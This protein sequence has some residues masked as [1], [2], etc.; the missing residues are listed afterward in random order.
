MPWL[1]PIGTPLASG[2]IESHDPI[3]QSNRACRFDG[4]AFTPANPRV[5]S[6]NPRRAWAS[7]YGFA[8]NEQKPSTQ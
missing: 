1:A 8:S 7:A 5:N 4:S 3:W 6:A 2:P